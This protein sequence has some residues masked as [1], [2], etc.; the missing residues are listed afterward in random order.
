MPVLTGHSTPGDPRVDFYSAQEIVCVA[1]SMRA[2]QRLDELVPGIV[3]RLSQVLSGSRTNFGH[4]FDHHVRACRF[5]W[6][7]WA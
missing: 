6:S 5:D 4:R 3:R 1:V 7:V 2:S